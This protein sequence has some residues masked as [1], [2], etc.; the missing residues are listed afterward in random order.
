MLSRLLIATGGVGKPTA[1][2]DAVA[3]GMA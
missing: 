2:R 1:M 3:S